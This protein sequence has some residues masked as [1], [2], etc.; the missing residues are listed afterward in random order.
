MPKR[1]ERLDVQGVLDR[2]VARGMI[3]QEPQTFP[4]QNASLPLR[5]RAAAWLRQFD[6]DDHVDCAL[7]LLDQFQFIGRAETVTAVRTFVDMNPSFR[8]AIVIPFGDARD[9]GSIQTYFTADLLGTHVGA[10]ETLDVAARR[11][12]TRSIII[13]DDF[14]GSGGQGR[15][16]LAAGF[17]LSSLRPQLGEM[18]D[19]FDGDVQSFLRNKKIAFVF[20]AAWDDGIDA[21]QRMAKEAGLDAIVYRHLGESD[22]P[23]AF[24][25]LGDVAPSI[26]GRFR[27]RCTEIG[28]ALIRSKQQIPDP[29]KIS[30]RALGYGNRG[31]LLASAFNVPTQSLTCFWAEGVV[32]GVSW[33]PLLPRRPKR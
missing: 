28:E 6:D 30:S 7:R 10:C 22:I 9:S 1:L 3:F 32:G 17:G 5:D 20:T 18:R 13:V 25:S 31:M 23:F 16:I 15:D 4:A 2:F 21:I 12:E 14:V 8:G 24:E 11:S 27:E 26:V 33:S 29:E 19:M